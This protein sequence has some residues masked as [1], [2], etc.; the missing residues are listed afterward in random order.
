MR[1]PRKAEYS[2]R[3]LRRVNVCDGWVPVMLEDRE[4]G[5][6]EQ[7]ERRLISLRSGR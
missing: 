1:R 6:L 3:T 4:A 2:A 7:T 5:E